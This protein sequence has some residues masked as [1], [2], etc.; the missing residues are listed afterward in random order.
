MHC[1]N[2][3]FSM[4]ILLLL[5]LMLFWLQQQQPAATDVTHRNPN[6]NWPIEM[7]NKANLLSIEHKIYGIVHTQKKPA[8]SAHFSLFSPFHSLDV[9]CVTNIDFS[10]SKFFGKKIGSRAFLC[11]SSC[12]SLQFTL[13]LKPN[14]FIVFNRNCFV[15]FDSLST[16]LFVEVLFCW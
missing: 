6:E 10:A 12:L 14:F 11:F 13:A 8:K 2:V 1:P 7:K 5:M 4:C 16:V 9:V 15:L 3:Q